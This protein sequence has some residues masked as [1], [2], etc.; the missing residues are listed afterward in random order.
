MGYVPS[1]QRELIEEVPLFLRNALID[2]VIDQVTHVDRDSRYDTRRPVGIKEFIEEL[3]YLCLQDPPED[4]SD[5]WHCQTILK[6]TLLELDWF[7]FYEALEYVAKEVLRFVPNS[8]DSPLCTFANFRSEVNSILDRVNAGW[9]LGAEGDLHRHKD[10][11]GIEVEAIVMELVAELDPVRDHLAK[12]K[13]YI[14]SR[15]SDPANSIKESISAVES[16]GKMMFPG[17][18][19]LGD[20]VGRL[21]AQ[22]RIPSGLITIIEKFYAFGNQEPGVRHGGTVAE[23]VQLEDADFCYGTALLLIK[24]LS[25]VAPN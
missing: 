25:T 9:R 24:Y 21:R 14:E 20:V 12:A 18:T 5:S 2:R 8:G 19:T 13:R 16:R 23:R 15:P 17:T 3:S 1:A 7:Y 6:A 4:Y 11:E 22:N 10:P